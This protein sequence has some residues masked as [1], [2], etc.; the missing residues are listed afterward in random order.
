MATTIGEILPVRR[1]R[2]APSR[3]TTEAPT[4]GERAYLLILAVAFMF[5][6][7]DTL[8]S[9]LRY[10]LSLVHLSAAWFIPDLLSLFIF[11]YFAWRVA[12]Q[13]RSSYA[14]LLTC[15][16][17]FSTIVGLVFMQ[18]TVFAF[19]SSIKLFLP[20]F[21]GA[22]MVDRSL[23]ATWPARWA[24]TA[25]FVAS[26]I[27]LL[28]SPYVDFPWL[29]QNLDNFGAV[30]QVGKIWWT[31]GKIRY[32]GF[33]GESTMAA[34]MAVIPYIVMHRHFPRMVNF[35]LWIP[36]YIAVELSTSK[37]ALLTLIAFSAIYIAVEIQRDRELRV[38]QFLARASYL[39]IPIPFILM[40]LMGGMDLT[41][42]SPVLFSMQDRISRT[43]IFPFT[44]L[45]E[46]APAAIFAG[47]GLGCFTYP[48]E[49]TKLGYLIVPV[50]NFY[51][52]TFIMMG[53][54][55]L[56]F[57]IGSYF[58]IGKNQ[59]IEKLLL[60]TTLN[61]YAVT[62]QC[63]G[64]STATLFLGYAFSNMFISGDRWKRSWRGSGKADT[65]SDFA[66]QT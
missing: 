14:I 64:P 41:K 46:N 52:A 62:V 53:L 57:V 66:G 55:F 23:T 25:L 56:V 11:F 38:A 17:L 13:R 26:T 33:A 31:G 40:P 29:G 39:T 3:K 34:Y 51:V 42:I 7:R 28:I 44:W 45:A 60:L 20:F 12:W 27:G 30:K 2:S 54:P 15:S 48:M 61:F 19:V 21:V 22:V 6:F 37:T 9:S 8:T 65:S 35:A 5:F 47:C 43:W 50:D 18:S 59:S 49:Y 58:T 32:G 10:Y 24:L 16:F 4:I 1:W 63:Y 36:L